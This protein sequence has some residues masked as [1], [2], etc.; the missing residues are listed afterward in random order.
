MTRRLLVIVVMLFSSSVALAATQIPEEQKESFRK[1]KLV[2][3]AVS[4]SY[5][6][7]G[8]RF[9]LPIEKIASELFRYAG[10]ET[11]K[12]RRAQ[13]DGV[14][15]IGVEGIGFTEDVYNP[16][17]GMQSSMPTS[18]HLSG[19]IKLEAPGTPAYTTGFSDSFDASVLN[20]VDPIGE[21]RDGYKKVLV[22]KCIPEIAD[23]LWQLYGIDP[24][25]AA[26]ASDEEMVRMGVSTELRKLKDPKAVEPLIA[27]L[28]AGSGAGTYSV[29]NVLGALGDARAVEPLIRALG[30]KDLAVRACAAV[31]LGELGDAR[32]VEPL[33]RVLGDKD[34]L[35]S[36]CAASALGELG[37]LRAVEPLSEKLRSV[38]DPWKKAF[39]AAL[40]ALT[41]ERPQQPAESP[42]AGTDTQ[43]SS[44][45]EAGK[46]SKPAP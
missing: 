4:Q 14:L 17:Y 10:V 13:P 42:A 12:G 35:V 20:F 2:K 11:A 7:A 9:S 33:I 29:A 22:A 45:E 8:R 28:E 34:A 37:D 41:A 1:I 19:T 27:M 23:I 21:M 46:G 26:M 30:H 43:Q 15:T 5:E 6:Y 3:I 39:S 40:A 24:L 31:A 36:A 16:V 25:L 18:G 44:P 38:S 32:A